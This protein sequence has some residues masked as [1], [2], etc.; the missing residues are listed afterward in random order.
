MSELDFVRWIGEQVAKHPFVVTGPG[1]DTAVLQDGWLVTTDMLLEGS[2]FL[3][4]EAGPRRVGRKAMAVNLSDI[5]AMAGNP[6]AAVISVGLPKDLGQ[7]MAQE[8]FL[9]IKECAD[10]FSTAI[11][12]G[13][14]NTWDGPLSISITLLGK[15]GPKGP[16]LRSG[17]KPGDWIFV[18]GPL[19]GSILGKHLDFTPRIRE[20]R[21]LLDKVTPHSMIDISDGL[22][23]DL[24]RMCRE[25]NCGATLQAQNIPISQEACEIG[26]NKSPLQ[27]ALS[28]GEDFE[29]LFTVSSED[30]RL[31]LEEQPI[32]GIELCCIG[33]II[34]EGFWLADSSGRMKL[35]PEGYCHPL[36]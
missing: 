29:L 18:T 23:L 7:S 36:D 22:A 16:V 26:D 28:D 21:E 14:T 9:G 17:A 27:H 8:L 5:A 30:G 4:D 6:V 10:Q 2:C 35:Q 32:K 31:I 20:A 25:S 15:A 19:G 33:E 11:V 34:E 1:E 24:W 13:D 12:G 3:L